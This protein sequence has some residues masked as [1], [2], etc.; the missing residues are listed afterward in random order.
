LVFN[1]ALTHFPPQ[2]LVALF[3]LHW[4]L[5]AHLPLELRAQKPPTEP[6][7][8]GAKFLDRLH[9]QLLHIVNDETLELLQLQTS[10]VG[11]ETFNGSES[12]K[13]TGAFERVAHGSIGGAKESEGRRG[14]LLDF[15]DGRIFQLLV[16]MRFPTSGAAVLTSADFSQFVVPSEMAGTVRRMW[17]DVSAWGLGISDAVPEFP[18]DLTEVGSPAR[19]EAFPTVF[20]RAELCDAERLTE[21]EAGAGATGSGNGSGRDVCACVTGGISFQVRSKSISSL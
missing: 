3:L 20:G 19:E 18:L 2:E 1:T 13:A 16:E 17:A 21:R 6:H 15:G 7:R 5:L 11:S 14:T 9:R 12:E 8:P 10:V 4:T